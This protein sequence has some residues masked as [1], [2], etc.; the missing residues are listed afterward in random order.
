[1]VV[2]EAR[3]V[4]KEARLV[5]KEARL[6]VKEARLV[7]KEA[8]LVVAVRYSLRHRAQ[9]ADV[10]KAYVMVLACGAHCAAS[11]RRATFYCAASTR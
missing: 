5:V 8:R 9:C 3:L 1:M 2:K 6:V 4:V 10:C 7:V 11:T